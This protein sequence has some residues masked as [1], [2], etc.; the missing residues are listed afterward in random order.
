VIS[1]CLAGVYLLHLERPMG[2]SRHYLGYSSDVGRRL[3][4][5]QVGHGAQ[6][7]RAALRRGIGWQLSRCWPGGDRRLES[8]LKRISSRTL[9]PL[10]AGEV[11]NDAA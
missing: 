6:F 10:C 5:H 7:L 9:C 4:Q 11:V 2:H 8:A 1:D 3:A